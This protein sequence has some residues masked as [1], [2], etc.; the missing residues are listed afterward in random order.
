MKIIYEILYGS[1][2]YGTTTNDSDQDIRGI[3]M[4][5]LEEV[6]SLKEQ[7]DIRVQSDESDIVMY[8]I[9]K[10]FKL[11][12]RSN[13]SVFE[14]L[15]VPEEHIRIMEDSA[16]IIRE[17]RSIFL[18]KEIHDRFKGFAWHEYTNLTK[19]TGATG[20]KRKEQIIEHGYN[21]KNAMNCIRLLEQGIELLN[22][23]F[24]TMPRPNA[25][26]LIQ[27]KLGKMRH[28]EVSRKFEY[29]IKE[30]DNAKEISKLP[31]ISSQTDIDN[32]LIRILKEYC[33]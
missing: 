10:F 18:S 3:L 15:F 9:N 1:D 29:L 16:K 5:S 11:A 25:E 4:P 31:D 23:G 7:Q 12:A 28:E 33:K 26:E 2:V 24:I 22:S 32:L 20:Y 17:N 14:W 13:P 27:I 30:I 19:M 6:F 8:P 21:P